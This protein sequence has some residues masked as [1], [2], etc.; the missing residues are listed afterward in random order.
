MSIAWL[1]VFV[2]FGLLLALAIALF[3]PHPRSLS[4]N[5]RLAHRQ[6]TGPIFRDDDRYWLGGL[7]YY[8]PDDPDPLVPK[9]FGF[10]WTMN[11]GHPAGKVFMLVILAMILLPVVLALL[12]VHLTPVGCHPSGCYPA[13]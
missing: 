9:R 13:P 6:L 3:L 7:F 11:F 8:N 10:G 1:V 4:K 5:H 12:G 2:L